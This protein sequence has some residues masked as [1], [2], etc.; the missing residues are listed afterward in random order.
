M[1]GKAL[2][3]TRVASANYDATE[4]AEEIFHRRRP[5]LELLVSW[6]RHALDGE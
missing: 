1:I 6:A 4:D 5:M 2:R 3:G